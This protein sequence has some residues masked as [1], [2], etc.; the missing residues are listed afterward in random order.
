MILTR[1]AESRV[2]LA[3]LD[4]TVSV[5][6][7]TSFTDNDAAGMAALGELDK[8]Y[9]AMFTAAPRLHPRPPPLSRS[10]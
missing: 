8:H 4:A 9:L 6:D 10:M 7:S 1:L 2:E 5:D 3:I